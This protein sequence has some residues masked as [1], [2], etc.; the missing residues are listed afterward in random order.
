LGRIHFG[1]EII[2]NQDLV[3]NFKVQTN[4]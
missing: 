3:C 2:A 1:E 4:L